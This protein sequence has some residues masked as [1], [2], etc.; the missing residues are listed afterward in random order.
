MEKR[1]VLVFFSI[2]MED[3]IIKIGNKGDL[4]PVFE[5]A[6]NHITEHFQQSI[7]YNNSGSTIECSGQPPTERA[8][9]F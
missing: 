9:R 5:M 4:E 7:I 8:V 3:L 1:R 2:W 6:R